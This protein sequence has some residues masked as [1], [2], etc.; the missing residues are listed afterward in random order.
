M[1]VVCCKY[2]DDGVD[3]N[4]IETAYLYP[5]KNIFSSKEA[6]CAVHDRGDK[7][8]SILPPGKQLACPGKVPYHRLTLVFS[9]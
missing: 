3:K 9:T 8:K 2:L 6:F 7:M 1:M 4:I 5:E